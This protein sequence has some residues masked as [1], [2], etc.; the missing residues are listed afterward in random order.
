MLKVYLSEKRLP[1]TGYAIFLDLG[2]FRMIDGINGT[3][4]GIIGATQKHN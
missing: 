1:W 3:L 2:G 4:S